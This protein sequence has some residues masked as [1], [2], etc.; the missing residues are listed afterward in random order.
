M[1]LY[2]LLCFLF[3]FSVWFFSVYRLFAIDDIF[4]PF[5]A[6]VFTTIILDG[7]L[8]QSIVFESLS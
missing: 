8:K 4:T 7:A 2:S 3:A 5:L 1:A 6:I